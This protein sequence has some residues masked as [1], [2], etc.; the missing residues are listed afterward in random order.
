MVD[1]VNPTRCEKIRGKWI[2]EPLTTD[3]KMTFH[4]YFNEVFLE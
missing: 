3:S 4:L 1:F 2:T